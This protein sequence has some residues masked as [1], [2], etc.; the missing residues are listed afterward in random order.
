MKKL[1]IYNEFGI[2]PTTNYTAA[3]LD[4]Y[5]P[6]LTSPGLKDVGLV[7]NEL[8]RSYKTSVDILEK[9][10]NGIVTYLLSDL[11]ENTKLSED[12]IYSNILN[13][14]HLYCAL[15]MPEY[16]N[17]EGVN[18]KYD[19]DYIHDFIELFVES[20]L[21]IPETE[22]KKFGIN[23]GLD[24]SVF[25]NSGIRVALPHETAGVFMNKSGKGNQGW[26]VRSQ[27]VDE[28]YTGLVHLSLAFTKD[29][30]EG[31]QLYIGDKITQMLI[32]PIYL[33][34]GVENLTKVEYDKV[35]EGSERGANA[36]GSGDIKH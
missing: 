33:V 20:S 25:F 8:S 17:E 4:F 31:A 7:W 30:Y 13:L 36:F 6:D 32:L 21:V 29:K 35:M 23:V 5:I 34:D 26:D 27:V 28:D 9:I 24:E 14:V 19:E 3:G 1:K 16:E 18:I 10:G 2:E 12:F 15:D 22:D 11:E